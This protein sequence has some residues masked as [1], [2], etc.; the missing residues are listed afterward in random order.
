[1]NRSKLKSALFVSLVLTSLFSCAQFS[2]REF[3]GKWR[4]EF[5]IRKG[6]FVPFNFD[7]KE[8]GKVILINADERFET[9]K[10][11]V[12]KDSLFIPLDQFD[13]ELAFR[14]ANRSLTGELR[15]QDHTGS[16]IPV[17]ASKGNHS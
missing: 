9:G 6:T 14:I 16:P 7:I 2:E 10:F 5:E 1:M 13:N 8:N 12:I 11:T 4:G 15:K 17:K 3:Y